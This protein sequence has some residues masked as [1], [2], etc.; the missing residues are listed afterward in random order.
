MTIAAPIIEYPETNWQAGVTDTYRTSDPVIMISGTVPVVPADY[1]EEIVYT[2][3]QRFRV[4]RDAVFGPYSS[5][6]DDG[7]IAGRTTA[8]ATEIPWS[9]DGEFAVE[10]SPGDTV[11]M[12]FKT[13][14]RRSVLGMIGSVIE[15][16]SISEVAVIVVYENQISAT[17]DLP[18]SVQ[19]HRAQDYIKIMVPQDAIRMGDDSDFAG[20]NFYVSL[21][22]GGGSEYVRMN[23]ILVTDPDESETVDATLN[24][25]DYYESAG[26]LNVHTVK[27]RI[28]ESKY[29][30]FS[31]TTAVITKLISE[32]KLPNIF[33]ADGTTLNVGQRFYFVAS[34]T[35]F[36][37]VLNEATESPYSVELPGSFVEYSTDYKALPVR[38]RNDVLFSMSH[39]L[40]ANNS[41][42]SVVAGSVIRDMMDPLALQFERFYTIQDF[43]FA[44]MSLDTL[45]QY[46][47][48]DGDGVSDPVSTNINKKKLAAALGVSDAVSLQ[49]LIDEQFDK[50]AANSDMTRHTSMKSIGTAVMYT[51]TAPTTDIYIPDG[52]SV[53]YPGDVNKGILP[54]TFIIK[55][56]YVMDVSNLDYYFNPSQQRWEIEVNLEAQLPGSDSNVP[57]RS[58]TRVNE[59]NSL[60]QVI[61][62]EPTLYGSDRETNQNLASRV[63][64]ARSSFDSGNESGY[65]SAAYDVPGVLQA[66]VEE[67][68]DPLMMRDYDE[69]ENK[70]IGGKVDIYVKGSRLVQVIDQVAFKYEY[71]VDTYGNKVGEQFD[72]ADALSFRLRSRNQKIT[73]NNPIV[74]VHQVR[75]VTRGADYSLDAL[76][77][78][79]DGNTI[80]LASSLYNQTIGLATMDV[81][82]V[83]YRYRSSNILTLSTQPVV[84]VDLVTDSSGTVIDS[85]KYRIM[86]IQDPMQ[87]G[88]S[89]IAQ[90]GVQFLFGD[91]DDIEEF[92]TIV[93][94]EHDMIIGT[95]TRLLYKGVDVSTIVVKNP[96][97]VTEIYVRDVDYTIVSGSETEYT[98]LRLVAVGKIRNGDRVSVDYNASKNFNVTYTVNSVIDQVDAKVSAMRSSCA[99]VAVKQAV[100]NFVDMSFKVVRKVGVDKL[101]L[102]S[103]IN[104]TLSNYV[105]KLKMGEPLTQ[106]DVVNVI[107]NV[108]GVKNV[109]IPMTNL[110]KRNGSFISLDDIGEPAFEIFQRTSACG[111]TSYRTIKP[112]LSYK[113]VDNGGPDNLFRGIY[114]DSRPLTLVSDSSLVG[115][116]L[117]RGYIQP[118][119]RIV[120][121]TTDGR[122]PQEKLY[123]VSYYAFYNADE[124]FASDIET[125]EIEYL[126]IDALSTKNVEIIDERVVKR[127]I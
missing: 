124:I 66:R 95:D 127:G 14:T 22:A 17:A 34:V 101:L 74:I 49:L 50:Y 43:I 30:T 52:S 53:S 32:G 56:S 13:V 1:D 86:K 87:D 48:A 119:G 85:S 7:M 83:D 20:C 36:D 69:G 82:E 37:K 97:D 40:M 113:T 99:D 98:Y 122:P 15:E 105:R 116:G 29:Y 115:R 8:A 80:I 23:D 78:T 60:L 55:G 61:N 88:N 117:G 63:K 84:S 93:N 111:F 24:V 59:G 18:T 121:S 26:D 92:E 10:P 35:A 11:H 107:R 6:S 103:R 33:L 31:F 81:V 108:S 65:S 21:D 76:Q 104:K 64:L 2:V 89:S 100:E 41:T 106:D 46:D 12:E 71:P 120:V 28:I 112:V 123:K 75:N 94:E 79:G 16:S 47:D 126:T 39:D 125:S 70:H 77:I 91:D 58:I 62:L 27:S 96:D 44:T 73:E 72:V 54:V 67:E 118:D 102:K 45:V 68:G 5:W 114:E 57:A 38:S 3:Q 51:T 42:V 90:D 19:M 4:E 109:Q 110:M 25:S 9:F